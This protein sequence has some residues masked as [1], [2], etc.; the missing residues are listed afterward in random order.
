MRSILEVITPALSHDL[1]TL[2]TAKLFLGITNTSSDTLI[3][4]LIKQVSNSIMTWCDR[5]FAEEEVS[6]EF[7][8][9]AD[10]DL[11]LRNYRTLR[12]KR[13]PVDTIASIS[14]DSEAALETTL[15][16]LNPKNGLVYRLNADGFYSYWCWTKSL[17]VAYTAG[18]A[19]LNELPYDIERAC[20]IWIKDAYTNTN[21]G[22]QNSDI[23]SIEINDIRT[24][25][26]FNTTTSIKGS[27]GAEPPPEAALLLE[28]YRRITFS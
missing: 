27:G 25:E 14:I 17:V 28:P 13:Y 15:Y 18:Y 8:P 1:T 4:M 2:A 9:E 20:L 24:I 3:S 16:K 7:L 6:E 12:L 11:D 19:L 23:K 21:A 10:Y 22:N 26:Y 5:V